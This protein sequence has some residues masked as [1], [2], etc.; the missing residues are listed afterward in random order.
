MI[1]LN[2]EG[3]YKEAEAEKVLAEGNIEDQY[4]A[5]DAINEKYIS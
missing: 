5:S 1:Y 4:I 2:I 3:Y